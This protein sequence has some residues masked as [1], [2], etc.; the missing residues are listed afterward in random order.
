MSERIRD[1]IPLSEA[2]VKALQFATDNGTRHFPDGYALVHDWIKDHPAAR[3]DGTVFWFEQARGINNGDSLSARFIRRHT[4]NGLDLGDVPMSVRKP[5]QELSDRIAKQVT[6]DLLKYREV[7]PLAA[8][9]DRDI[10]VALDEGRVPLGGWGGS[11]YYYDMPFNPRELTERPGLRMEPG[12][13]FP[14]KPDG[15]YHTVGDEIE[16]RGERELLLKA[17]SKTI[18]DMVVAGEIRL[19]DAPELLQTSWNAGM[20]ASMKAEV[21]LRASVMVAEHVRDHVDQNLRQIPED[22]QRMLEQQRRGLL[23]GA[24]DRLDDLLHPSLPN[25]PRLGSQPVD[26]NVPG[27]QQLAGQLDTALERDRLLA[28]RQDAHGPVRV[29]QQAESAGHVPGPFDDPFADRYFAAVMAGDSDLAD[30][31]AIEFSRTP[32]GQQLAQLGDRLLAQQ[33]ALEQ[34]QLEERTRQGPVMQ[35]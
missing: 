30:R 2:Q 22:L 27:W 20:P 10:R 12:D 8:I 32:E 16:A 7:P 17:S 6:E 15:G 25:I 13:P 4:E 19:S 28:H 1:P 9:L 23:D 24:K 11:F 14:R 34:Q 35:M 18:K 3:A 29:T 33:Q 31:I 21:T 26:G 5:M